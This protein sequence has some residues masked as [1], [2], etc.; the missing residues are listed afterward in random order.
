MRRLTSLVVMVILLIIAASPV[1]GQ[2][3]SEQCTV[4][5]Q[6]VNLRTGPG[7]N[8]AI[9][10]AL[11]GTLPVTGQN[12]NSTWYS[13][14]FQGD[15]VWVATHVVAVNGDCN[16]VPLSANTGQC[17]ASGHN[18]NLRTG[19]DVSFAVIAVLNESA[20]IVGK[21]GDASWYQVS[22]RG[23]TAWAA[24]NVLSVSG[25]CSSL[26]TSTNTGMIS[27]TLRPE[28]HRFGFYAP[29]G[30][31][32][33]PTSTLNNVTLPEQ[34]GVQR[35]TGTFPFGPD[36]TP[37]AV[38]LDQ[39]SG[40]RAI[41]YI[42]TNHDGD[43]TDETA[44][45]LS[46]LNPS[47]TIVL[48]IPYGEQELPGHYEF[49]YYEEGASLRLLYY[50][51]GMRVGNARVG[52]SSYNIAVVDDDADGIFNGPMDAL[53]VDTNWNRWYEMDEE[54]NISS[55]VKIN[56]I[57][58]TIENLTESGT[59]LELVTIEPGSI[60]GTVLDPQ[61]RGIQNAQVEIPRLGLSATTNE[62][63]YYEI[64]ACPGDYT[65]LQIQA[66]HPEHMLQEMRLGIVQSLESYTYGFSLQP[67]LTPPSGTVSLGPGDSYDFLTQTTGSYTGGEFYVGL[68]DGQM[69]FF[70]N[71]TPQRGVAS[72]GA[73]TGD[74]NDVT[75]GQI[76]Q[77]RFTMFGVPV[78]E[79][80]TYVALARQ[81]EEG[82]YVVFR[83]TATTKGRLTLDYVYKLAD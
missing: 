41:F 40:D 65:R 76:S 77:S 63:G 48:D 74:L 59:S 72:F 54:I 73:Y 5:G 17:M 61:G 7:T 1:S 28:P 62:Q 70:C 81:G 50:R 69:T 2:T 55:P 39:M 78:V 66:T 4:T 27:V 8:H 52:D 83:V 68:E 30:S 26:S 22:H 19:P 58:L 24:A 16:T 3:D 15:S 53:I 46:V 60:S 49:Y 47:P 32:L 35:Y 14:T 42:D 37:F 21:N 82:N 6:N 38:V 51:A 10:G 25:D 33:S 64:P 71:N 56:G 57:C 18:I 11:N 9:A 44:Y 34:Q 12:N 45:T 67:I 36:H 29:Q 20:P 13:V 43:L 80:H 23:Q 75:L 31:N 79:G